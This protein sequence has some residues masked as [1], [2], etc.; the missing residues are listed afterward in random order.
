MLL[1]HLEPAKEKPECGNNFEIVSEEDSGMHSNRPR[2]AGII[3]VANPWQGMVIGGWSLLS[4][5]QKYFRSWFDT[6]P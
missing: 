1:T 2:P 5:L 4:L 3:M 6:S